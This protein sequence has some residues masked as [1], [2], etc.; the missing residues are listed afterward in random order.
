MAILIAVLVVVFCSCGVADP[1][2]NSMKQCYEFTVKTYTTISPN[3]SG[4]P[5]TDYIYITQCGL[6]KQDADNIKKE[7]T[8]SMTVVTGGVTI[9][10]TQTCTYKEK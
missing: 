5:K 2:D 1:V 4:Y 9:T 7:F 8:S 3:I 10:A 6:S